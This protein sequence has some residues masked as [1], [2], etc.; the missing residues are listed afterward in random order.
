MPQRY[1]VMDLDD[2][3]GDFMVVPF[4]FEHP[5]N[6]AFEPT[7]TGVINLALPSPVSISC[8]AHL[9]IITMAVE[10]KYDPKDMIFRHLGPT[11]LKVS[12]FSLGPLRCQH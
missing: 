1:D 11:G 10:S 2:G 12:I 3:L 6:L 4:Y 9:Y 5:Q 8:V 7:K